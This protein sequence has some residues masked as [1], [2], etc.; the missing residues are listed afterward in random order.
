ME[1]V[2]KHWNGLSREEQ[3]SPPLQV[4]KEC[5]D[6]VLWLTSEDQSQV[7]PNNLGSLSNLNDSV[8]LRSL[9][10]TSLKHTGSTNQASY[11]LLLL[12]KAEPWHSLLQHEAGDALGARA[13]SATHD[14]VHISVTSPADE[15][16]QE[17]TTRKVEL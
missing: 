16:L 1:K 5:L 9:P 13:P 12:A 2:V 15:G 4:F 8:V 14:H 10:C 3:E 6:S 11:L 7:G 17:G